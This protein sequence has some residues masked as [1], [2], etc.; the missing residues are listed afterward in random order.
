MVSVTDHGN[1]RMR[2]RC[3]VPKKSCLRLAEE[4]FK[5]GITYAETTGS[6]NKYITSLYFHNQ[7]ANNIRILNDKVFIFSNQVLI[8]V[9]N[10]PP[11]YHKNVSKLVKRKQAVS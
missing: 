11:R 7:T 10:L 2:S 9:L 4:A 3:G 1:K 6:L 5:N 8:T